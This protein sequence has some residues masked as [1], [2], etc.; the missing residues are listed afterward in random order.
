[1]FSA[2]SSSTA[3]NSHLW[4]AIA[5][6]HASKVCMCSALTTGVLMMTQ[7]G[8]PCTPVL[9][10]A[11]WTACIG[12]RFNKARKRSG[13][14]GTMIKTG[15]TTWWHRSIIVLPAGGREVL[16][17]GC[18]IIVYDL[19]GVWGKISVLYFASLY[20]IHVWSMYGIHVK[21]PS[22]SSVLC[23]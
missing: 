22:M 8:L 11:V 9:P 15:G 16:A 6:V 13:Q 12:P 4:S 17:D 18:V 5:R 20:I 19:P 1:M 10:T 7:T 21:Q 14:G 23:S 3:G 2:S